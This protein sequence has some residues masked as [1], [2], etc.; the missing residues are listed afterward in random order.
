MEKKRSFD[1]A[2]SF[3]GED[4]KKAETLSDIL[5]R[6][7]LRVFYDEYEKASLWGKNL[8]THLS[9]VYQNKAIYCIMLISEYYAKKLWTKHEREAAQARAF[10]EHEEYILPI[11]LDETE[12]PGVSL[13]IGYLR[14]P[15]ET[16]ETIADALIAKLDRIKSG[17]ALPI[18]KKSGSY[19]ENKQEAYKITYCVRCGAMPGERSACTI[20]YSHNFHTTTEPLYCSRCGAVPGERSECTIGYSHQF[21][22]LRGRVYC[23]RCGAV[24]G[25]SSECTVGYSHNFVTET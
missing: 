17:N 10:L 7:G 2:I 6:R 3:A 9:D 8:Y 4:R 5:R 19:L 11:R 13:T 18:D 1:V 14:W 25:K 21:Q 22:V 20:G 16:P 23:K 15:P 24:P 12:I